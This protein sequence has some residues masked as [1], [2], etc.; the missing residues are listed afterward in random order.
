M[1]AINLTK[2]LTGFAAA[3]VMTTVTL[4]AG[5]SASAHGMSHMGSNSHTLSL[6]HTNTMTTISDHR[7][8]RRHRRFISVGY[9]APELVCVYKRTAY[10]LVKI[11]PD[12]WY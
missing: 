7:R 2:S 6:S 4:A 10:G 5:G 3:I 12:D 9:V 11:C 1:T 8:D